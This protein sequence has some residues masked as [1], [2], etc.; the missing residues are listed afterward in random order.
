M[1]ENKIYAVVDSFVTDGELPEQFNAEGQSLYAAIEEV[2]EGTDIQYSIEDVG[3][4]C[5][6]G[7]DCGIVSVAY[8][9][10]GKLHHM[11]FEW[12]RR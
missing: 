2:F 7:Y 3:T 5:S 6:P 1:I 10:D 8:I 11:N 4:F 9:E 12:E